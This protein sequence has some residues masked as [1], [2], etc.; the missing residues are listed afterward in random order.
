MVPLAS[1]A[2]TRMTAD[3]SRRRRTSDQ[4]MAKLALM[5]APP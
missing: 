2:I 4:A 1:A 3:W 5:A